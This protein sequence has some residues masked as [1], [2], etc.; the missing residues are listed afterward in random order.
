MVDELADWVDRIRLCGNGVV[1]LQASRAIQE[2]WA[3]LRDIEHLTD[4]ELE[5]QAALEAKLARKP[6]TPRTRT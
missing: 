4:E 3:A 2:C 1:P 6:R 5:A